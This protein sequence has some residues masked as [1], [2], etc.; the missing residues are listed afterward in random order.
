[1]SGDRGYPF[2][3]EI[4]LDRH[5]AR[6]AR[7]PY[8]LRMNDQIDSAIPEDG[9]ETQPLLP[10]EAPEIA[11]VVVLVAFA[12]LALG[13][14]VAG[15]IFS[16]SSIGG[17]F[18]VTRQFTGEAITYGATWAGPLL[19]IA[20]L[21]VVGLGWWQLE[22]WRETGDVVPGQNHDAEVQGRMRRAWRIGVAAQV[23]MIVTLAGSIAALVGTVM[24][25]PVGGAQNWSRFVIE[26]A[27]LIGV[28]VVA[29]GGWKIGRSVTSA[30]PVS[31]H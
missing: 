28:L 22:T 21:G 29:A 18:P 1:M 13:G 19:A 20:L 26:G 2:Q 5:Q 6:I 16:T 24:A 10:W 14:L 25:S 8:A 9:S 15:I 27:S 4:N 17:G 7:A 30:L 31:V 11:A 23:A 12:A 3:T